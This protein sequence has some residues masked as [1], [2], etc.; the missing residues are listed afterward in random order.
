MKRIAQQLLI[1]F[2]IYLLVGVVRYPYAVLPDKL[3]DY[4]KRISAATSLPFDI[5]NTAISFPLNISAKSLST[6]LPSKLGPLSIVAQNIYCNLDFVSLVKLQLLSN[7]SLEVYQ[8]ELTSTIGRSFFSDKLQV[9]AQLSNVN[10]SVIDALAKYQ[11]N[12]TIASAWDGSISPSTKI[13]VGDFDLEV[14]NAIYQGKDKIMGLVALPVIS[15]ISARI[16]GTIKESSITAKL[17]E[18]SSSLGSANA[19]A[20]A[21]L[22]PDM[23]PIAYSAQIQIAL[24]PEGTQAFGAYLALGSNGTGRADNSRWSIFIE[25][26]PTQNFPKVITAPL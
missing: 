18:L 7:C 2:G 5:Q 20:S 14:S 23:K 12:G 15:D 11:L 9:N 4:L 6:E 16:T 21:Q 3:P 17:E 8:G 19:V 24:S 1:F 10:L 26:K 13:A 25:K 22:R